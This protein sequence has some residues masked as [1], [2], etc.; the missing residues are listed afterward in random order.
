MKKKV[1]VVDDDDSVRESLRKV[2]QDAGYD[3]VLAAG[4]LEAANRFEPEEIDLL[5]LDLNLPSQSGWD[6]FEHLTTRHP[7]VPVI[8]ITG[9]SDQYRTARAAGVGALFEK[10]VEVPALLET[11]AG[12]LAETKEHRLQRLCGHLDNLRYE[13]PARAASNQGQPEHPLI[14]AAGFIPIPR[15]SRHR[16]RPSHENETINTNRRRGA[17]DRE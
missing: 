3:V 2:L 4:G 5:L 14:V 10:P 15:A 8:I 12:L 13:P 11:M 9:M 7:F 16:R 6:V 17:P 1:L